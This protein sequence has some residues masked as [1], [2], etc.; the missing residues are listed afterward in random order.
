[1]QTDLGDYYRPWGMKISRRM[2]KGGKMSG[3]PTT[4]HGRPAMHSG[5]SAKVNQE[6]QDPADETENTTRTRK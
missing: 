5:R 2:Y 6:N 3:R 4:P 1:M